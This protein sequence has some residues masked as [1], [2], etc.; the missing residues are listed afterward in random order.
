MKNLILIHGRSWKPPKS[1]LRKL[2]LDAI[3]FGIERDHPDSLDD[4]KHA[5]VQ[6]VYYGDI[7]NDFLKRQGDEQP[8]QEK[9]IKER[10]KTLK[11]L[12]AWHSYQFTKRNYNNLEGKES[13]KEGIADVLSPILKFFNLSEGLIKLA[14]P[15]IYEYWR[16]EESDFGSQVRARLTNPLK[17]AFDGNDSVCLIAHSLGSMI[18]YDTLWKFSYRSEYR[19]KYNHKKVDLFLTIGTPLADETVK[20]GLFGAKLSGPRRYPA[21]IRRW[22]NFAAEDDY[23]SHD[24]KVANDFKRMKKYGLID[25]IVDRHIYNLSLRKGKSNPHHS[26]GYLIHPK[27]TS[28][29]VDW[30][31]N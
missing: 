16:G 5:K 12:K 14:A 17:R 4:F 9:D 24:S 23:I 19:P 30:L 11:L 7:S 27:V 15:D 10:K 2:W 3:R 31:H 1:D 6:F 18:S 26:G 20:S 28:A 21:N 25:K 22:V 13:F 29:I 8:P